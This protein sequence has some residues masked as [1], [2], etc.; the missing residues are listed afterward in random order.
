M[1]HWKTHVEAGKVLGHET[2]LSANE[3]ILNVEGHGSC[4]VTVEWYKRQLRAGLLN[5]CADGPP[6]DGERPNLDGGYFVRHLDG[7]EGWSPPKAFE[8]N[9]EKLAGMNTVFPETGGS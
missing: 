2:D 8:M 4:P 5:L 6:R 1:D 7:T 3:V 9:H